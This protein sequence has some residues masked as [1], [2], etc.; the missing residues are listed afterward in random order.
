MRNIEVRVY[1]TPIHL[2]EAESETPVYVT[3]EIAGF[4]H[5]TVLVSTIIDNEPHV[6]AFYFFPEEQRL[7]AAPKE[8]IDQLTEFLGE[9]P[10]DLS[11]LP[12]PEGVSE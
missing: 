9:T 1:E 3:H 8:V 6:S 10:L 2:K 7:E 5:H 11:R 4:E 12:L